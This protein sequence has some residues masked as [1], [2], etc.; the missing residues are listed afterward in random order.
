[1]QQDTLVAGL[2]RHIRKS[3]KPVTILL[4]DIEGSTE[5]FDKHGDVEGRLLVDQHN[6]L[7]FP[8]ISRFRGKIIKTTGDGVMASFRVA[9][10]AIKAAIGIQQLLAQQRRQHAAYVPKVRIGVHTGEA[11]V[12]D[13]DVFGDVVNVAVR[14]A[15]RGKGDEIFVSG[16]TATELEKKEFRLV[17]KGSFRPKGKA[18]ALT[19]YRCRWATHSNLISDIQ[20]WSFLPIIKQQKL[21]I[22]IY[23]VASIGILYFLYLSYLRYVAADHEY[24]ALLILN[25]QMILAKT[26]AIPALLLMVTVAGAAALYAIQTVPYYLLRLLKGG[27]GFCLGFLIVYLPIN[28]SPIDIP[29]INSPVFQ[30]RHLFVEVLHSTHVHRFPAL[31][32]EILMN[33]DKDDLLL[34]A[35]VTTPVD[36]TWNKVL[37]GK[38]Q[39]GWVP[40]VLPPTVGE[41][42]RRLT[43]TDK[44]SFRYSDLAALLA[45]LGG[46]VWGFLNLRIRP[47]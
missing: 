47:T 39:Y 13:E 33:A 22:F 46:F 32:S 2:R 6:R 23:F 42:E 16:Q 4:T 17:R 26:P 7:I 24:L 37:I 14:L 8:V 18:R 30:S 20:L 25:P 45:G 1:M 12:E 11:I 40:R 43:L 38:E 3:T 36:I 9:A 34:L 35:D 10:N 41:P 19:I 28:Y 44:F 31:G 29:G 27:F 5:Y 15:S 21:E